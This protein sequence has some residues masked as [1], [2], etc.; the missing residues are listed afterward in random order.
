MISFPCGT[1]DKV[2]TDER[3]V[4]P[5]TGHCLVS[6]LQPMHP[7]AWPL[8]PNISISPAL[9]LTCESQL[10]RGCQ[11]ICSA[12]GASS[13][14]TFCFLGLNDGLSISGKCFISIAQVCVRSG[15]YQRGN[16]SVQWSATVGVVW[17]LVYRGKKQ[18]S[19]TW[20]IRVKKGPS[21]S[22]G[23]PISTVLRYKCRNQGT[24][25][26]LTSLCSSSI[27]SQS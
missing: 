14:F 4:S 12:D 27:R 20:N 3:L 18:D 22:R 25:M 24:E 13:S 5:V 1:L 21:L 19:W 6:F 23:L 17:D 16:R 2:G 15:I 8:L 10:C 26:K 7:A 9:C 11:A